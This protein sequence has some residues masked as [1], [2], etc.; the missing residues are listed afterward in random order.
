M[1]LV[2]NTLVTPETI[3]EKIVNKCR[4]T[5]IEIDC[6]SSTCRFVLVKGY[7]DGAQFVQTWQGG[8]VIANTEAGNDFD[9]YLHAAPNAT[10]NICEN[11]DA[12]VWAYLVAKG[13]V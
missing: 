11:A 5:N 4:I 13:W 2:T 10:K 8:G 12:A 9:T 3:P 1:T 6:Q 7:M